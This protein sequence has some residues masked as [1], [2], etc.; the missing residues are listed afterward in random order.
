MEYMYT[1]THRLLLTQVL[2]KPTEDQQR[3]PN[4]RSYHKGNRCLQYRCEVCERYT[5]Q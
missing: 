4:R 2:T 5:L 1:F 3:R